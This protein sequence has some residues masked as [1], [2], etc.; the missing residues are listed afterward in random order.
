MRALALDLGS[1]TIGVAI[2]DETRMMAMPLL[3]LPRKGHAID[4]AAILAIAKEREVADIVLGMPYELNGALG[5]RGRLTKR[6][7]TDFVQ[8]CQT[9]GLSLRIHVWD[10]R[11]STA[12][13]ERSL[14]Q[15]DVSRAGRKQ[16]IDSVAA[17]FILE[18]WLASPSN[19]ASADDETT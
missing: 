10:E 8:H 9:L 7:R 13:A 16:V 4:F 19:R 11:F 6:W 2:S 18:G 17:Q 15:A 3:V 1:K 12:A 5:H 14:L